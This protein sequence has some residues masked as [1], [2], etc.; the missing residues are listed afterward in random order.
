MRK[1]SLAQL[2]KKHCYVRGFKENSHIM[3][4]K[5]KGIIFHIQVLL[6][7]GFF[8]LLNEVKYEKDVTTFPKYLLIVLRMLPLCCYQYVEKLCLVK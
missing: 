7:Q 8:F 3:Y 4:I 5:L 6:L 2:L 1:V